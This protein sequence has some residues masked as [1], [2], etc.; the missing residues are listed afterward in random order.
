ML[1]CWYF[2]VNCSTWRTKELCKYNEDI[3]PITVPCPVKEGSVLLWFSA[4]LDHQS[5]MYSINQHW[6]Q[7]TTD[8]PSSGQAGYPS[9]GKLVGRESQSNTRSWGGGGGGRGWQGMCWRIRGLMSMLPASNK[10]K[11]L[12]TWAKVEHSCHFS[13]DPPATFLLEMIWSLRK[14]TKVC[15]TL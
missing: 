10:E 3:F 1:Y 2:I 12:H 11:K 5:Y 4:N 6:Q 7:T 14:N 13:H 15:A 9:Q 8:Y